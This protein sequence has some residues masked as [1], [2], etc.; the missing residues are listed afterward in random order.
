MFHCIIAA[1]AQIQT[2]NEA[3]VVINDDKFFMMWP[4]IM[5]WNGDELFEN[6]SKI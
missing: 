4:V 6:R 2:S 5:P 3:N 1:K